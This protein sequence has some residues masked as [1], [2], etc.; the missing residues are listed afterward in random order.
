MG[1][2]RCGHEDPDGHRLT[3]KR[4][5]ILIAALLVILIATGA[6]ISSKLLRDEYS[7][8]STQKDSLNA[9]P[10]PLVRVANGAGSVSIEAA[11]GSGKIEYEAT[12]YAVAS[13]PLSAQER[14]SSVP[15]DVR[16]E[17][18]SRVVIETPA[19]RNTGADYTL[20]VPPGASVEVASKAGEVSVAGV[21]GDVSVEA[22]AGDVLVRDAAGTVDVEAPAGDVKVEDVSTETGRV[23]L[24]VGSGDADLSDLVVGSLEVDVESGDARLSGRF[25]GSGEVSVRTGDIYLEVPPENA[26]N[27]TLETRVGEVIPDEGEQ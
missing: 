21:K 14:A 27:L 22:K 24:A 2:E 10:K 3:R 20:R 16:R 12:K 18:D 23:D 1:R 6:V 19:G 25:S 4:R 8:R 15:V 7:G 5:L 17:E 26:R 11:E 9:G 13:D